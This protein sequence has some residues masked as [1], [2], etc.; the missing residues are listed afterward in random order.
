[1]IQRS[2]PTRRLAKEKL[3]GAG[4]NYVLFDDGLLRAELADATV[5][6]SMLIAFI[7]TV[8]LSPEPMTP[9]DA[10]HRFDV[11]SPTTIRELWQAAVR[12][13]AIEKTELANGK[14]LVARRGHNWVGKNVGATNVGARNVTAH[15]N[16]ENNTENGTTIQP[17]ERCYSDRASPDREPTLSR[18]SQNDIDREA[19][20][21]RHLLNWAY[22]DKA[23]SRVE[24]FLDGAHYSDIGDIAAVMPDAELRS[25]I[26]A[27]TEGRVHPAILAPAG[28]YAVRILAAC[29]L[30][31]SDIDDPLHPAGGARGYPPPYR[32]SAG[33]AA[34][35]PGTD[36]NALGR[37]GL[38]RGLGAGG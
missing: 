34:Q 9:A 17:E 12:F 10:T 24:Q 38:F 28:L 33:A 5:N 6:R 37:P 13:G 19:W 14:V 31:S 30:A 2:Q 32:R 7:L 11:T 3:I 29:L 22:P 4:D 1:M 27:A 15:S 16:R 36:R 18:A 23:N 25:A 35:F 8:N 20:T 26:E 21:S